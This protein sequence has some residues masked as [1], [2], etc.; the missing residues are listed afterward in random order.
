LPGTGETAS[1]IASRK[2]L[3]AFSPDSGHNPGLHKSFDLDLATRQGR[4][5][6]QI[7][8]VPSP[9]QKGASRSTNGFSSEKFTKVLNGHV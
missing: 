7:A 2:G 6:S 3:P 4:P 8:Q 9:P 5:S 1:I